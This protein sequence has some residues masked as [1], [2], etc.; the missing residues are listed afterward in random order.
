MI[1][2]LGGLGKS[3]VKDD[4]LSLSCLL[5]LVLENPKEQ[6]QAASA[7]CRRSARAQAG[8]CCVRAYSVAGWRSGAGLPVWRL[9]QD[10][11]T[12]TY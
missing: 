12:K 8:N 11:P 6:G 7:R 3:H 4:L 2:G 10:G 5:P 1:G 9:G